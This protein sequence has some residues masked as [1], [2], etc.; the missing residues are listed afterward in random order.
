[1]LPV[2]STLKI[3]AVL[4][5]T[6]EEIELPTL[7]R[8]ELIELEIELTTL[9]RDELTTLLTELE[10][11]ELTELLTRLEET[12]HAEVTPN[13]AGWLLQVLREIQLL[14]FS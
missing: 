6:E 1:M 12:P 4:E 9:E 11:A 5:P 3:P 13:G 7:E 10:R 14:L 8:D 2:A